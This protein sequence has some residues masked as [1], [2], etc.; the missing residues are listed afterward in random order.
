MTAVFT[1]L[2]LA[3]VFIAFACSF[4]PSRLHSSHSASLPLLYPQARLDEPPPPPQ[5]QQLTPRAARHAPAPDALS[6]PR[7]SQRADASGYSTHT[8]D[9]REGRTPGTSGRMHAALSLLGALSPQQREA[10]RVAAEL[11]R[12]VMNEF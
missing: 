5:Q 1:S 12:E 10:G 9:G 3:L 6:T 4:A 8:L 7:H 2:S 11:V